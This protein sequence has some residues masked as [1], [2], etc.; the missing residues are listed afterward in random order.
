MAGLS[1]SGAFWA[2][3]RSLCL[4]QF[5]CGTGSW[6][7]SRFPPKAPQ[8][9]CGPRR[10]GPAPRERLPPP[11]EEP[12]ESLTA[13]LRSPGSPWALPADCSLADQRLRE[14]AV[15]SPRV[16]RR[17]FIFCYFRSLRIVSK[18][19]SEIDSGL[20]KFPNLEELILSANRISTI[21]SANL[22]PTLK[23][24]E[25]CGNNVDGLRDLCA[26]PP[27]QLQHLGLGH[28]C[29]LGSSE[30]QYLT[31]AFW[32]KL[33][34]LDLSYNSFTSLLSLLAHLLTLKQ[35]RILVLQGNPCALLPGYRGFTID[36]LPR[37]C[38]LDDVLITL[39]E[40][41]SFL[42][43]ARN[44]ELLRCRAKMIVTIGKIRGVP[45][46]IGPEEPESGPESP[47]ITYSYYVTYEFAEATVVVSQVSPT[48]TALDGDLATAPEKGGT[49]T[50]TATETSSKLEAPL[51]TANLHAT[52]RKPWAETIEC[53]YRKE[54]CAQDVAGLKAFLLAGTTVEVIEE[55]VVSWP[56][57]TTPDESLTKKGKG[58]PEKGK[59]EKGK[60]EKGKKDKEKEKGKGK[61]VG[62]AGNKKKKKLP[63]PEL[64]SDP[65]IL[66]TLGSVRVA[67]EGL[68]AGESL[69]ETVC[70]FGVLAAE[71]HV[72]PPSPKEKDSKK[73]AK[74]EKKP[75]A[76]PEKTSPLAK[77][78][79]KK[80]D[81]PE[82]G[83]LPRSQ[84][85]PLTVEF[86][87]Q[88]VKW[89]SASQILIKS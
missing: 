29:R 5:P 23:V 44:P 3:L 72:Q 17:S 82:A 75:K 81:S 88:H 8:G 24:L 63:S 10:A 50:P 38:A 16:V 62:K 7:K 54:H 53:D 60:P 55:K 42:G 61:D 13:F 22:P 4:D 80:K 37:L 85:I 56:I 12:A 2:H 49:H 45:N 46:P 32:P 58:K 35:L 86:Q 69:L 79:G 25:L 40:R 67:L 41:H 84:P 76:G 26:H 20:L 43:L 47:V 14:L 65:P 11:D 27:P 6:N 34:S 28:N 59:P 39:D 66:K 68:L 33:V 57:V 9:L 64:R 51:E 70:D 31:D 30:E 18:D 89:T 87:M 71:V 48:P 73:G 52:P 78:K 1:A 83:E 19:V 36:S 77:G 15:Q 74:K 21:N